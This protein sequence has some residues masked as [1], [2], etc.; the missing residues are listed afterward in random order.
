VTP[1]YL[2]KK[3]LFH[4]LETPVDQMRAIL[5]QA[6]PKMIDVCGRRKWTQKAEAN[7]EFG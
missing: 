7:I 1:C 4:M 3:K 6:R 2:S 5:Q